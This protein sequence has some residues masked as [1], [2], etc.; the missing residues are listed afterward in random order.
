[1]YSCNIIVHLKFKCNNS[2][3]CSQLASYVLYPQIQVHLESSLSCYS[4]TDLK[5]KLF[6]LISTYWLVQNQIISYRKIEY[7]LI[8]TTLMVFSQDLR[9]VDH[10][11]TKHIH[12]Y[13]CT[14]NPYKDHHL[15]PF[16]SRPSDCV[17]ELQV[18][19]TVNMLDFTFFI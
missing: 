17:L 2:L 9:L 13:A 3:Q 1:M 6:Q 4:V 15:W 12:S 14:Q 18:G 7:T 19:R 5:L 10:Q 11:D 8:G 16:N